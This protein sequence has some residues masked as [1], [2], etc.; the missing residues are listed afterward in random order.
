MEKNQIFMELII[1][2]LSSCGLFLGQPSSFA[3]GFNIC[4]TPVRFPPREYFNF[5]DRLETTVP[6]GKFQL[7]PDAPVATG[8]FD[9]LPQNERTALDHT[10]SLRIVKQS[11]AGCI[12]NLTYIKHVVPAL[13]DIHRLFRP[14]CHVKKA[15]RFVYRHAE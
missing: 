4:G 6:T 13:F 12:E 8:C 3:T 14:F 10:N 2:L 11:A 7:Q 5:P 15:K 9:W 1:S